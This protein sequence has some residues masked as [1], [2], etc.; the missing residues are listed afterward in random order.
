MPLWLPF[1]IALAVEIEFAVTGVV[2]ASR[3]GPPA[4]GRAP[5]PADIER[6]GWPDGAP[7]DDDPAFWSSGPVARTH[8]S[9]PRRLAVSAAVLAF[10]AL[11]AWG[12]SLR[13]G[14][15]GLDGST[16]AQVV[17]VLSAQ[18][19][20]IAG[21]RAVVHCD[22]SGG[23]VGA[24]QE[25]DGLAEVGGTNAWLTP[26][27]CF[28]LYRVVDHHDVSLFD[29]TG[30]AIVVLAHESWHLHGYANEGL[31]N[32]F[33]YQSGVGVAERL[34]LSRAQ[35]RALM[36]T[37]LANN[38]ADSEGAEQYRVPPGCRKGGRYDLHL[39]GS[40]FP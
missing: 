23:H 27:I 25:A 35:G 26:S 21:H 5:Q 8:S 9:W 2:R 24:V 13:R 15:S 31:V 28:R 16:R 30:H 14:W 39:D 3:A 34:G 32:C 29:P 10:V 6:F 33:A 18:A 17:R 7:E 36:H 12:V 22:T 19:T 1:L 4:R 20:R 11:A 37:Q 38:A 40:S